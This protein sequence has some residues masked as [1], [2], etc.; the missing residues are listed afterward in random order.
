MK[1]IIYALSYLRYA[2]KIIFRFLVNSKSDRIIIIA[3][4]T[5][6]NLGDQAIVYAEKKAIKTI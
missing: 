1:K 5:H 4:P 2:L 3:T 6:G